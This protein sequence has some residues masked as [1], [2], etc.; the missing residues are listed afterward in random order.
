MT[1][2][3]VYDKYGQDEDDGIE[4]D[5]V[6]EKDAAIQWCKFGDKQGWFYGE[7][8]EDLDITVCVLDENGHCSVYTVDVELVPEFKPYEGE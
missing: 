3:R 5:T 6:D 7:D 1:K 8:Y 2:Y 4:F